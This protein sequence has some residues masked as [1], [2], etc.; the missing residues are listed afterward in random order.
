M[1]VI[2]AGKCEYRVDFSRP[3]GHA[4]LRLSPPNGGEL[5][6]L[7]EELPVVLLYDTKLSPLI[8]EKAAAEKAVSG[9]KPQDTIVFL[10]DRDGDT[11]PHIEY[12]VLETASRLASLKRRVTVLLRSFRASDERFDGRYRVTRQKGV[13][14]I[15]YETLDITEEEGIYTVVAWDGKLS[16]C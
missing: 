3:C 11:N 1:K 16:V 6:G 9:L 15:K 12:R 13:A 8:A 14:F 7:P 10:M 5:K 2:V 4:A